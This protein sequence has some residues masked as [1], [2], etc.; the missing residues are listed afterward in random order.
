MR[1]VMLCLASLT[2]TCLLFTLY[3]L[4]A[5]LGIERNELMITALAFNCICKKKHKRRKHHWWV[6]SILKKRKGQGAYHHLIGE[7]QE[8]GDRF[9]LFFRLTGEQFAQVL[10][11]VGEDLVKHGRCREG[12]CPKKRSKRRQDYPYIKSVYFNYAKIILGK[13]IQVSLKCV[14]KIVANARGCTDYLR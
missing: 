11:L 13:S 2:Q 14:F 3:C 12:I 9:Q 5:R 1:H 6:H 8:D 10:F 7:L 4:C